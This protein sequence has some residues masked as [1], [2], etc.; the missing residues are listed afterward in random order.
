MIPEQS[1]ASLELPEPT[2]LQK[3][4]AV[5]W[6]L[7]FHISNT[8]FIQFTF[9]GSVFVLFLDRL[10]L[11]KSQIGFVLALM[12]FFDLISLFLASVVQRI[13]YRRTFLTFW[14]LRTFFS[15]FLL[16]IPLAIS[17][18]GTGVVLVLVA[19]I[20]IAFASSRSVAITAYNPWQH[21]YIPRLM[22]GK[23]SAAQS[24][25]TSLAGV[26]AVT[27]AGYVV[28]LYSDL[29]GYMLLF[30]VALIFGL[31]SV[32]SAAHLPGGAPVSRQEQVEHPQGS[33]REAL[34][35]RRYLAYLI[36][37]GLVALATV[38]LGAFVPLFM[39]DVVQISPG[40]VILLT[41]GTLVGGLFSGY[42]WGWAA[43]RYGSRPVMLSGVAF[44]AI[45]PLLWLL[46]PRLSPWSFPIA[47]GI[48]LLRGAL[49]NSWTIGSTRMLFAHVVPVDKKVPYLAVYTAWM[50][51]ASGASQIAGG[52]LLDLT[53]GLQG[54]LWIFE[55]DPY[56]V[57]FGLSMALAGLSALILS[58][59]RLDSRVSLGEFAGLFVQG[60]P[61]MAMTSL[62]RYQMARDES[63][64]VSVT[65][66]LGRSG[67]PLTVDE[68]LQ[69]LQDPRFYVRFEAIVSIAR[70]PSDPRLQQALADVLRGNDPSLSVIAAWALGRIGDQAACEP[71]R[72]AL[73]SPYRSIR[74]H[75]ARSLGSLEDPQAATL[76]LRL[77]SQEMDP[78]LRV[79]YA[80]ALGRL[81]AQEA[82]PLL[83]D[84]LHN[85]G[86]PDSRLELSLA[87]A[88]LLGDENAFIHTWRQME[89]DP[90][91]ALSQALVNF[92]KKLGSHG[93]DAAL[94]EQLNACLDEF[95]AQQLASGAV[96]LA[97]LIASLPLEHADP[98]ARQMLVACQ[99]QIQQTGDE[100]REYLVLALEALNLGW[101][102]PPPATVVGEGLL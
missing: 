20:V 27:I 101:H 23:Y 24:M 76:L 47:M 2:N 49:L 18:F 28:N 67:S 8:F 98:V 7:A 60:N 99:A 9:F 15:A 38:P 80:S 26:V 86:E 93:V 79:A 84:L 5:P 83:L 46:M 22:W 71:L 45:L 1:S 17:R 66:L 94:L 40:N 95:S 77:L 73:A 30:G 51:I 33:P 65:E 34:R 14:S 29:T 75:A 68:L 74:A 87:L 21:E 61:L 97:G 52:R 64:T 56:T 78:G 55:I 16:L 81:G 85:A 35:D 4:R 54:R 12:P 58:Q 90:G 57:L 53:A 19:L 36:G 92:R 41:T 11:D 59:V 69:A 32:W 31:L 48:A 96:R 63:A 88:R 50:G 70:R 37:A 91:T 10:Q 13:G 43:D 42:L 44:T 39:Q 102:S 25:F 89:N 100:R 62:I 72:Q 3:L 6:A 82:T